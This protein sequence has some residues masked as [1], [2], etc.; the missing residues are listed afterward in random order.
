MSNNNSLAQTTTHSI[1]SRIVND[2]KLE[3]RVTDSSKTFLETREWAYGHFF[4]CKLIG[5]QRTP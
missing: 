4:F 1:F 3:S 5:Y 2:T